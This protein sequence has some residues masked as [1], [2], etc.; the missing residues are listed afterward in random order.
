[1][2]IDSEIHDWPIVGFRDVQS[3]GM[4]VPG[5]PARSEARFKR[6]QKPFSEARIADGLKGGEHAARNLGGREKIPQGKTS[7]AVGDSGGRKCLASG[8]MGND[9]V[10][11]DYP[12]LTPFGLGRGRKKV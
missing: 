3:S 5:L 9:A 4:L 12:D 1:V 6:L 2:P 10:T 11:V 8:V 7:I